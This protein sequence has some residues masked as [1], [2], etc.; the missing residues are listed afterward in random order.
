MKTTNQLGIDDGF[1]METGIKKSISMMV[2][3]NPIEN[4]DQLKIARKKSI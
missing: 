4:K 3:N 1:N 2:I